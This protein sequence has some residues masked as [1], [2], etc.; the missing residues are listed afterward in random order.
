MCVHKEVVVQ[1]SVSFS[2]DN[3]IHITEV[4]STF[5]TSML[6]CLHKEA[7]PQNDVS[8]LSDYYIIVT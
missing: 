5:H 8:V 3:R 2:F 7:V 1:S 6:V 4:M